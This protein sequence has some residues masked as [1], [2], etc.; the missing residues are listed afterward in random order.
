VVEVLRIRGP[1]LDPVYLDLWAARLGIEA[2]LAR[3]RTDA[4][5]DV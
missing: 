1:N 5:R 4:E 2:L 3:A